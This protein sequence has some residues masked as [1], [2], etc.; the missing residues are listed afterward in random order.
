[1]FAYTVLP[2]LFFSA[3]VAAAPQ[4]V[5]P[6]DSCNVGSVQCCNE[7][8]AANSTSGTAILG[9]LGVALSNPNAL[10]GFNCNPITAIGAGS[11]SSCQANPVCC[12]DNSVGGFIS[13][14]CVPINLSL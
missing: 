3:L 13:L 1:M 9:A 8:Q 12:D 7:V 11:G 6:V 4:A 5:G 2:A 10:L 14:G